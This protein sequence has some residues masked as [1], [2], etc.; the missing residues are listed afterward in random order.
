MGKLHQQRRPRF[1]APSHRRSIPPGLARQHAEKRLRNQRPRGQNL[2][3]ARQFVRSSSPF[4]NAPVLD[5]FVAQLLVAGLLARGVCVRPESRGTQSPPIRRAAPQ[6]LDCTRSSTPTRREKPS[7]P[8]AKGGRLRTLYFIL[9]GRP[10]HLETPRCWI[11]SWRRP[12]HL[13]VAGLWRAD[14]G[15]RP[16]S[17][18]N[19]AAESAP[20]RRA[21]LQ[22]LDCTRSSTPTRRGKPSKPA[23]KRADFAPC[24]SIWEALLAI[25]KS[26]G[27][28]FILLTGRRFFSWRTLGCELGRK[29]RVVGRGLSARESWAQTRVV[30]KRHQPS[31]PQNDAP[32]H[33]RSIAAGLARQHA[34]A[35]LQN[36]RQRGQTPH[37]DLHFRKPCS[38]FGNATVLDSFVS[39]GG[40]SF[41]S[42]TLGARILRHTR[43]VGK[44][45]QQS[46]AITTRWAT[47]NRLQQV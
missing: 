41:W 44:R 25:W 31:R 9:G 42:R 19:P 37:L 38:P 7:K 6:R 17:W 39:Q 29:T 36:S 13:L 11:R 46:A 35:R 8:A 22:R 34:E 4:G 21:V 27:A 3:L 33:R 43:V 18:A 24:T 32:S 47:G 10:R 26:H 28:R 12:A 16:E 23:T 5:S 30:D 14:S 1:D 40:A 45:H 20:I 15:H 2:H